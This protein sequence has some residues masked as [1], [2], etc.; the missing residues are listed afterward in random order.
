MEWM[1]LFKKT[2]PISLGLPRR[3]A[4]MITFILLVLQSLWR[5]LC[6]PDRP[7][8]GGA[9]TRPLQPCDASDS[10]RRAKFG[11]VLGNNI[12]MVP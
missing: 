3:G 4:R 6:Y 2:T 8:L 9:S 11:N 7:I 12:A 10:Q 5:R 1:T